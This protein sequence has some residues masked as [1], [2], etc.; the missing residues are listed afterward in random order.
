M[1]RK[2]PWRVV[3]SDLSTDEADELLS[4]MKRHST[5]KNN[6]MPCTACGAGSHHGMRYKLLK[7]ESSTCS[8]VTCSWR[9][10]V[11]V[12]MDSG[13]SYIYDLGEHFT[14]SSSP[15]RARLSG[16]QKDFCRELA[17]QRLRPLRIQHAMARKFQL[18]AN[19]LS[20]LAKVQNFC[21]HYSR[22]EL[23]NYARLDDLTEWIHSRTYTG[24]EGEHDVF[25][26]AWDMDQKGKPIVGDG[27]DEEP[28][29]V[30]LTTKALRLQPIYESCL[31]A[32]SRVFSWITQLRLMPRFVM[33][34]A[35]Q[36]QRNAVFSVFQ[37]NPSTEYLMCF[38][39]V[40]TNVEKRLKEFPSH[41]ASAIV[42]GLYDLH[43]ARDQ[44]AFSCLRDQLL[45]TWKMYPELCFS[46]PSG[47]AT[48]N[49]PVEQF[50]K[51]LKRDYTLR[52]RLKMGTL[53]KE[54][55]DCCMHEPSRQRPFCME[56]EAAPTLTRRVV[57]LGVMHIFGYPAKRIVVEGA[58][59]STEEEM[60]L[61]NYCFKFGACVHLVYALRATDR[62]D[63][64]GRRILVSRRM[65]HKRS[66]DGIATLGGMPRA[67][68]PALS[69]D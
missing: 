51:V 59:R 68:G 63:G 2:L 47:F 26:F 19:Y 5:G 64:A 17:Q 20:P 8:E 27:S 48:T 25:T 28:F 23:D 54:L 18:P 58:K 42:G 35:E 21:N 69:V 61:C 55:R 4:N 9:G 31:A 29:V 39:H 13:D 40:M 12:C 43:F 11:L 16:T 7:C 1:P 65:G 53:L 14:A 36:G 66:E 67:I 46:T 33:G 49:N 37:N 24:S 32:L 3:G 60:C 34:D 15:K 6:A 44:I 22:R 38:Y 45:S 52:R 62:M 50:N 10:K 41:V 57:E 30:G 56:P